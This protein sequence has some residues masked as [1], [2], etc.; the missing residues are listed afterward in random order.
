MTT[1]L[2]ATDV[3]IGVLIAL[4]GVVY[5]SRQVLP[6]V[7]DTDERPANLNAALLPLQKETGVSVAVW[8][9][10]SSYQCQRDASSV[11]A[12]ACRGDVSAHLTQSECQ[13]ACHPQDEASP[14]RLQGGEKLV[15]CCERSPGAQPQCAGRIKKATVENG[16]RADDGLGIEFATLKS[17]AATC[18]SN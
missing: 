8:C 18:V 15:Y 13:A 6:P 10:T 14:V 9:C 11:T 17:C 7:V 3:S 16:C 12:A 4:V 1:R 2:T 5:F